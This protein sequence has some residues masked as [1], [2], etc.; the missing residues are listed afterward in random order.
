MGTQPGQPSAQHGVSRL[1]YGYADGVRRGPW[2]T[3]LAVAAAGGIDAGLGILGLSRPVL[4]VSG[5]WRSGTTWLQEC[6][7]V[8]LGAKTVFEPLSPMEPRRRADLSKLY[9]DDGEDLW[10]ATVPGPWSPNDVAW[11]YLDA[12][13][14]GRLATEYLMSCRRDVAES[15]RPAIVVKDVRLQAN[16]GAFQDRYRVP[17]VHVRRHPCAVVA[18]LLAANWHWSFEHAPLEVLLPRLGAARPEVER[19]RALRFDTDALHRIAAFWAVTERLAAEGLSGQRWGALLSYERFSRDPAPV[20]AELC[21][22]LGL[23]QR[24]TVDFSQPSASV[25]PE[26]F[27]AY[28]AAP[29]ERWRT[30][31]TA[32]EISR[33]ETVV[34]AIFPEWR[35]DDITG[36]RTPETSNP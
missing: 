11:R 4:L 28:G 3:A 26:A 29:R 23:G 18:S 16:L 19:A 33:I 24:A 13:C 17:V 8:A 9:P 1:I 30:M 10:Q 35:R 12:A 20:L 14:S 32:Q 15:L 22:T 7:A 6:L 5:F 2:R 34:D 27:A 31:L 21:R 36:Q 25:H